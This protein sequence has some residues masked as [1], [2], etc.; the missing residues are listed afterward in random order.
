PQQGDFAI[1]GSI[2]INLGVE[3]RGLLARSSYGS[4]NTFRQLLLWAPKEARDDTF[5]AVQFRRSD[6]FGDNRN[7]LGASSM[8]QYGFGN[9][10]WRF[11]LTGIA[12]GIRARTAGV[13]RRDDIDAGRVGFYRSYDHPTADNQ[14][15]L[16]TRAIIGFSGEHR[17]ANGANAEVGLWLSHDV[18]RLQANYTGFV[19]RSEFNSD[20]VGRGDLI[21]QQNRTTSLGLHARFR[22]KP[23][24]PASWFRSTIEVG[25]ATRL[26]LIEQ[27]QFLIQAPQNQ[28]WDERD[29]ADIRGTDIGVYG[30]LAVDLTDFVSLRVGARADILVYEI[31][32]RLGNRIP[33]F[34]ADSFI[35]G[36]RRSAFGVAAGPRASAVVRPAP[37]LSFLAS[38]GE[39]FRSPQAR[40]LDDGETAP[41]SK[42]RGGDLGAQ[43]TVEEQLELRASGFY[44]RLSDD[45]AFEPREGRLERIG[46]TRRLGATVHMTL[47]PVPWLVA[48]GSLTYVDA[49]LLE[50]PPATA[51]DPQPPFEEG[52]NLPYV[53]PWVLR[54]DVGAQGALGRIGSEDLRG[55]IGVGFNHLSSRPLPFG[56]SAAPVSLLDAAASIGWGPVELGVQAFNLA[57]ARYAA[58]AFNFASDWNTGGGARSR[59]PARH[60][61][62]GAPRTVMFTLELHL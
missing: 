35:V 40:T 47:R 14:N 7:S 22:T 11:R 28:T 13:L 33:D 25:L 5:A 41:F 55:R 26:D 49:E 59:L 2:N 31:D 32:D 23:Y 29:D 37:W 39:G 48:A 30:D 15:A 52:Q 1:A 50:P 36:F 38:Y 56:E 53:P 8:M 62:A 54:L 17:A 4:F 27:A 44:T 3:R 19:E 16:S 51:D 34:R 6:G 61:A 20:W 46:A 24:K 57:D 18:F 60:I 9:G 45:V 12:H 42:V 10:P 21:E 58:F 43:I